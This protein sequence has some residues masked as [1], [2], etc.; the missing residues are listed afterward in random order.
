[1]PRFYVDPTDLVLHAGELVLPEAPARH[2]VNVLRLRVGDDVTLF[3]GTGGEWPARIARIDKRAVAVSVERR[4]PVER[5]APIALTL[6]Q[7]LIAA[8]MMDLIVLKATELGVAIIVPVRAQR[9][10]SLGAE[11]EGK[12]LAHWRQIA[13]AAC[14]Q[15]GRNTLPS[16]APVANLQ[17]AL[18]T[19]CETV[20][21]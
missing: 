5:E 15:C 7:S 13:I 14:E 1:M 9:S 6:V 17:D 11:R 21:A 10:Q 16:I 8:D 19:C 20:L 12:R 18:R 2:A 3:D 4:D